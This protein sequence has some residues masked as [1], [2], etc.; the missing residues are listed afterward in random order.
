MFGT[1]FGGSNEPKPAL[2]GDCFLEI[3]CTISEFYNGCM[4][5]AYYERTALGLDGKTIKVE[6]KEKELYVRPGY[7]EKNNLVFKGEGN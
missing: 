6:R 3:P 5:K 1:A 2:E 7:S 4:K